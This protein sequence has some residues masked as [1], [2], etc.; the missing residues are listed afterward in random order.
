MDFAL[1][2][3]LV[4]TKPGGDICRGNSRQ[5]W[6]RPVVFDDALDCS[7]IRRSKH[8]APLSKNRGG[9]HAP[10]D[11]FAVQQPRVFSFRLQRVAEG[12]AEIENPAQ[13]A[14]ALV[15]ADDLGFDANRSRNNAF[16][17]LRLL[18]QNLRGAA[19]QRFEQI[20]V[21]DHATFYDFVQAGPVF[22]D[23]QCLENSGIDQNRERLVKTAQQVL[24]GDKIHA[25]FAPHGRVHLRK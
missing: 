25:G 14:F 16:D 8:A 19:V 10:G 5:R 18:R 9:P 7:G 21:A 24:A 17:N 11:G 23:R 15:G 4:A 12:V 22:A 20:P 6:N 3:L 13:I 1:D 2:G